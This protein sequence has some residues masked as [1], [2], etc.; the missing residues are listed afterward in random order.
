MLLFQFLDADEEGSRR[1]GTGA[2]T[3]LSQQVG[4]ETRK[5]QA[6]MAS[7]MLLLGG[8]PPV[9]AVSGASWLVILA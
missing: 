7:A 1:E 2:W 3:E 8:A 6:S 4:A 5:P 9:A